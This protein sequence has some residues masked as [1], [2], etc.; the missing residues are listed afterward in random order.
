MNNSDSIIRQKRRESPVLRPMQEIYRLIR[1]R[2]R[3]SSALP[4]QLPTKRLMVK[5]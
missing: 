2:L 4:K 3:F 5:K 1:E